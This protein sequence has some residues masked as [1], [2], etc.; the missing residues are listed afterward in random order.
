MSSPALQTTTIAG[1]PANITESTKGRPPLLFLHGAFVTHESFDQFQL[2]LARLGW[3]GISFSRRGRHGVQPAGAAGLTFNDYVQDT[4]RAI[5]AIGE[6][7]V[8]IGHSLG[9]LIAQKIME[10]G[11][12]RAAVLLAPAPA[13]MLTAQPVAV[14]SYLPMLP[15]IL[16][17]R[18]FLPPVGTCSRIV[19]NEVPRE[20]HGFIHGSLVP[21]SGKVYREMMFGSVKIDA[22]RHRVPVSVFGGD[23][24]RIISTALLDFTAGRYHVKPTVYGDHGHLFFVEPGWETVA[25]DVARWLDAQVALHAESERLLSA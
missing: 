2:E 19:L 3:G 11:R 16:R 15:D 23:N 1:F 6:A 7:P 14:P 12:C 21:E 25:R 13:A 10:M 8:L 9:G 22:S 20:A 17:G 24:D 18:S 5:D 4:V